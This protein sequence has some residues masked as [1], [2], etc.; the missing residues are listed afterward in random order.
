MSPPSR[1]LTAVLLI[2]PPSLL[3]ISLDVDDT[4][5]HLPSHTFQNFR[6]PFQVPDFS[7]GSILRA[8][9][10]AAY[11]VQSLYNG[12]S[13]NGTLGKWPYP[14]YFWWESG[15]SWNGMIEYYHY[16][17]DP[18]YL[19]VT[20]QGLLSQVG[21]AYDFNM[22]SEAFDEG[23][24]DQGFLHQPFSVGTHLLTHSIGFGSLQPCQPLNTRFLNLLAPSHHGFKSYRMP[25]RVSLLDGIPLAAMVD[26]SGNFMPRT[27]V[28]TTRAPSPMAASSSF[29]HGWL[30]TLEIPRTCTGRMRYGTGRM[31]SG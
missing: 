20:Y 16:T 13:T 23:N 11:G 6:S 15:A 30:D 24:D 1:L 4:G 3:A 22:P 8:A 18:Q 2:F 17:K 12:N 26:S 25:G 27:Q 14:P 7:T 19:D 29:Q 31:G 10:E 9:Q 5:K 21:P 28:G